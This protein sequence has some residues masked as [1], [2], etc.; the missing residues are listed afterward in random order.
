VKLVESVKDSGGAVHVFS[1]MHV[2]GER[3]YYFPSFL[4]SV[5][6]NISLTPIEIQHHCML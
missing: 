1:S 5:M 6:N 2:S 4:A 3:K